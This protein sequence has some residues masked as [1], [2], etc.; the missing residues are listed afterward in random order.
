MS[1][2]E[3]FNDCRMKKKGL[4]KTVQDFL[5]QCDRIEACISDHITKIQSK[6]LAL[7]E[8][9]SAVFTLFCEQWLYRKLQVWSN[10]WIIY[11]AVFT[12]NYVLNHCQY[13]KYYG[14]LIQLELSVLKIMCV[15]SK[16][17]LV[18][19][20][21]IAWPIKFQQ[22][23]VEHF[24]VLK[25]QQ[26]MILN[27]SFWKMKSITYCK[28]LT[29]PIKIYIHAQMLLNSLFFKIQSLH[30][31]TV[32]LDIVQ[33]YPASESFFFLYILLMRPL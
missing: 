22:H 24:R 27:L 5:A 3:N 33:L 7:A 11:F 25:H 1:L 13:W 21:K 28:K 20:P 15:T 23:T 18:L 8:W 19:F 2:P 4:V 31:T 17:D 9:T 14:W 6:N 29:A 16:C 32:C 10:L 30:H 26:I 12:E